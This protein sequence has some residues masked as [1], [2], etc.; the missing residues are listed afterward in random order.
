MLIKLLHGILQQIKKFML[1][2]LQQLKLLLHNKKHI[3]MVIHNYGLM[4]LI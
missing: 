1:M 2:I 3:L 4:L